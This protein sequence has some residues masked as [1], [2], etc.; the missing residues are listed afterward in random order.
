MSG[1]FVSGVCGCFKAQR[2]S[3]WHFPRNFRWVPYIQNPVTNHTKMIFIFWKLNRLSSLLFI[4]WH[5]R[6]KKS[7]NQ[8]W[9]RKNINDGIWTV[10]F[11]SVFCQILGSHHCQSRQWSNRRQDTMPKILYTMILRYNAQD[12][13]DG[14]IVFHFLNVLGSN[15]DHDYS[16]HH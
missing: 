15:G 8:T 9:K 1:V 10:R 3:N 7:N 4:T 14:W 6:S 5:V 2:F 11:L 16:F 13:R 12:P